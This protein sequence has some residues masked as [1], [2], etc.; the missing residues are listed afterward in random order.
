MKLLITG[1]HVTPALA[2]IDEIKSNELSNISIIFVGRKWIIHGK[3]SFEFQ[4]ITKRNIPFIQISTGRVSRIFNVQAFIE[5]LKIPFGFVSALWILSRN[6]PDVILSFGGYLAVPVAW[7]GFLLRI[8]VYTHEQTLAPGYA[9]RCIGVV[10]RK[11]FCSFPETTKYFSGKKTI[12][13]GNPLRLSLFRDVQSQIPEGVEPLLFI[14]GGSM[15]SHSI[16][17]II[18]DILPDLLSRYRVIHQTGNVDDTDGK[19][20]DKVTMHLPSINKKRYIRVSHVSSEKIGYIYRKADIVICRAGANTIWEL[21]ALSK[22]SILIPLPWSGFQEQQRH[23]EYLSH[24]HGAV[25]FQ[26]NSD[27]KSLLSILEKTIQNK[28]KMKRSLE[29][30]SVLYKTDAIQIIRKEITGGCT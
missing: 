15:G 25:I 9:N 10:A 27:P 21:I 11:I 22:P 6:R 13:T 19:Q 8:P 23:A 7:V 28:D 3:E 20:L 1:G 30:L 29:S 5:L 24:I 26:Q 4:E 17:S 2:L 16:N 18:C 14:L 12:V